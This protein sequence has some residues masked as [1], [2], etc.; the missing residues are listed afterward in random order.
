GIDGPTVRFGFVQFHGNGDGTLAEVVRYPFGRVTSLATA[1]MDG[2]G[3]PDVIAGELSGS[4]LVLRGSEDGGLIESTE[5]TTYGGPGGFAILDN[6]G[7][8]NLIAAS[9]NEFLTLQVSR[10]GT[11]ELKFDPELIFCFGDSTVDV[12]SGDFNGDGVID[13]AATTTSGAITV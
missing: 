5:T 2:D 9:H 6:G 13:F 3:A 12:T 11:P 1:D 10:P 4:Q 8:R 7:R